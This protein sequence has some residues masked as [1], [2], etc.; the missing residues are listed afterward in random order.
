MTTR[1]ELPA[2]ARAEV[3]AA[4]AGYRGED[5][6]AA[7]RKALAEQAKARRRAAG[8]YARQADRAAGGRY[9]AG[10]SRRMPP[11]GDDTA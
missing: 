6:R 5:A 11:G 8:R 10:M 9:R 2:G 1:R 4:P 3:S 7:W